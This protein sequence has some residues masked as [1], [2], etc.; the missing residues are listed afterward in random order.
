VED[1]DEDAI[2]IDINTAAA[3]AATAIS[4]FVG[5]CVPDI[6]TKSR[7]TTFIQCRVLTMRKAHLTILTDPPDGA[8]NYKAT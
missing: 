5:C 4:S 8:A 6:Q 7:R 3:A 1:V 2:E